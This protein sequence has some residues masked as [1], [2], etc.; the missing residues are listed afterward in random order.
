MDAHLGRRGFGRRGGW[1]W[2]PERGEPGQEHEPGGEAWHPHGPEHGHPHSP[3]H[4]H[5]HRRG[6]GRRHSVPVGGPWGFGPPMMWAWGGPG[7]GRPR[8]RRGDVRLGVLT[9]LGEQPMHGYQII[10]ELSSRS[11]GI[12]RPSPGSIYPALAQLED[13]GLVSGSEEDGRRTYTLTDT[14]RVEL[15]RASAGRPAPWES[16]VDEEGDGRNLRQR[17]GQVM[18]AV[19]Q[20][21]ATGSTVQVSQ[22]ERILVEA[23]RSLY[24]VLAEDDPVEEDER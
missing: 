21:A 24:R 2:Q 15:A 9:L 20:V 7:P 3:G 4:R 19:M 5:G 12:W 6:H 11:G 14:G 10:T 16:L 22:A 8:P 1:R 13:E 18:A 17:A 23:R